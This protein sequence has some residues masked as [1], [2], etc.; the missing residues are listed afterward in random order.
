MSEKSADVVIIGSGPTGAAYARVI[1][2]E[3]PE[4]RILMVEAG[5]QIKSETGAHLDNILDDQARAEA[6]IKAQGPTPSPYAPI[7]R[8]EWDER[9]AGRFDASLLRRQGLY[10]ANDGDTKDDTLFA[11]FS[12]ANVGGMGT[13]WTTGCPRPSAAELVPFIHPELMSE[14]LGRAET[15]LKVNADLHPGDAIADNVRERLAGLFNSGRPHDRRVRPMPLAST[16]IPG[17]FLRHGTDV[18]LGPMV[19]EPRDLFRIATKT[20]CRRILHEGG[21]ASGVELVSLEDDTVWQVEAGTVIVAADSLHSP[22]LLYA[23][24]IRPDALGRYINDH[25]QVTKLIEMDTDKPMESMSWIP[26][27]DDWPFSVTIAPTSAHT[28]PFS[29]TFNGQPVFIGVFC[30]SDVIP[31]NRVLFDESKKDWLGLPSISIKAHKTPDDLERLEQGKELA[32]RIAKT[33]GRPADGFETS[34]LPVGSSLHYQGTMRMGAEDDGSSVCDRDSRVW[35]F[36]NLYVAGN[37]IIPTMTA[38]NPTLF[39]VALAILGARRIAALKRHA[40]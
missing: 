38:T 34:V 5:P 15:L 10:M 16:P 18:I 17:G 11:G 3:W 22:Q 20:A 4:A 8:A 33:I 13:K 9:R 6:E 26:R 35:C 25:Y 12:A 19:D 7:T 32:M 24:G 1:R 29:A 39:S 23:S 28:L 31:D 30:A 14:A 37:G 21:K 27:A 40:A 2:D 36:D